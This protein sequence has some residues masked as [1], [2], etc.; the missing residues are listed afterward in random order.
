MYISIGTLH[1]ISARTYISHTRACVYWL[2]WNA[3]LLTHPSVVVNTVFQMSPFNL[4]SHIR[5]A[6]QAYNILYVIT[7]VRTY[8]NVP[9]TAANY[10]I[11]V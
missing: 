1:M 5:T 8:S 9:H 3:K 4:L 6:Y 2:Q 7:Y 10:C 11:H